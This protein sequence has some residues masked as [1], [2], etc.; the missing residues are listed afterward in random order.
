MV[1][2]R[3]YTLRSHQTTDIYIGSTTQILCKRLANHRVNYKMFI[4][5]KYHYVTSFEIIQHKDAYIEL[6]FEGEFQSK[7]DLERK[8]GE[9]IREMECVNKRIEGRTPQERYED[10]K[11]H[12]VEYKHNW[13]LQNKQITLERASNRYE[14][15]REHILKQHQ[16]KYNCDCGSVVGVYYK[17]KHERSQKHQLFIKSLCS[18]GNSS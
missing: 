18:E 3:I 7:N 13:Y 11:E 2:G 10:N 5:D 9:Y 16:K 15:N 17:A 6:L 4:N 8:E 14:N 1:F 12:F